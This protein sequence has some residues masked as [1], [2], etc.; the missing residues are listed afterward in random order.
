M[1]KIILAIL[2]LSAAEVYAG[3]WSVE[4]QFNT[5]SNSTTTTFGP[6]IHYS[7]DARNL[8]GFRA[9]APVAGS[10][11]SGTASIMALYRHAFSENKSRV[12][13]EATLGENIY[14]SK[15][16]EMG[17]LVSPSIGTNLGVLHQLTSDIAIGG[18]AGTEWTRTAVYK[19][20][21]YIHDDGLYIYARLGMFASMAF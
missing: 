18:I 10:D 11:S 15:E 19:D 1:K 7:W 14:S 21:A 2:F 8:I 13:A 17:A 16:G 9:L 4:G 20:D 12:F 6:S 5:V 3:V